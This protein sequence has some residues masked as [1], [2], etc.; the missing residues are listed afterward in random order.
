MTAQHGLSAVHPHEVALRYRGTDVGRL[1]AAPRTARDAFRPSELRLLEDL[2]QQIAV[3]AHAM[4]V[5]RELQRS[6]ESLVTTREEERRRIRRDLHDGLGPTLAG[7]ALGLDA[8]SRTAATDPEASASLAQQLKREVHASLAE[9]R[10]LVE[11][12]R[13][14]ALDQLGLA[15]AVH[16]RARQLSERDPRLEISVDVEL[17][18]PLPAAAEVAAYRIVTEA[19]NNVARHACARHCTVRLTTDDGRL[20]IVVDDDG[21]GLAATD[22]LGV[23]VMAM[24]ERATELG[25][26]CTVVSADEGGTRVSALIPVEER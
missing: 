1:L 16:Q 18:A 26:V 8:V 21:I 15:G 24:R 6:R 2:G 13:P 19:L 9:V 23:G 11:D 5:T 4:L 7:V 22:R 12:L 17:P 3:A 14:P 25:G 20:M 10:R